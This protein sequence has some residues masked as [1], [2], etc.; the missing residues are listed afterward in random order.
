MFDFR[1]DTVTQ[2]TAAM[3]NAM[4]TAV[5]GD[6]VYGDDPT[7]NKLESM[8]A[9]RYGFDAAIFCSSGTQ[10]NLL[11]IMAHCQRGD[12][13]ICGQNAHNYRWEGGGA[14]VLGSVQPQPIANEADGSICLQAIRDNIKPDDDHH[15]KTKLLSLENTIGGKV[16]S[17][18]YL[19]QAQAL[20]FEH[21]LRIH[22]DGAR[23]FNAA[24]KLNVDASEITQYFDSASI[25]LS[26]G[27][28]AP[29]GSLL[30]GSEALIRSARRWRKMLGGGMRQ[31][32]ILA[33]A[34][35]LALDEQVEKLSVDHDNAQYL[36][37][38]LLTLPEFTFD[39][40][41]VQTNMIF[42]QYTG[43]DGKALAA[44]L[45]TKGII[46]SA[47]NAIRFVVHQDITV[48]AIDLL[49]AEIKHFHTM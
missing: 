5:V 25:C 41:S 46:I 9:E 6:D 15:A 8:A 30:L 20:A 40:D 12:E 11:A 23:V 36:A 17:L 44:Y 37:Q 49:I 14:A 45:R 29:V 28:A 48:D 32:G 34:G 22:L 24:V 35:I 16:L 27:L 13:Y 42:T 43:K 31:A 7:V 19:A 47:S 10:A 1:S 26:K 38:Q 3:R 4:A 21:G 33:A 18:E 39:L 2:P